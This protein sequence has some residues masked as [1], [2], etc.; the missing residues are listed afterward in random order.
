MLLRL[1]WHA[2]VESSQ[3]QQ[4]QATTIHRLL[5]Y[6]PPGGFTRNASNPIDADA[7]VV[8]ESSMLDITLARELCAALSPKTRLV[9]IGDPDQ[10]PSIGAGNVRFLTS[11][12]SS[13]Y[14]FVKVAGVCAHTP[15]S[16]SARWVFCRSC[17]TRSAQVSWPRESSQPSSG[18]RLRPL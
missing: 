10:L 11:R 6:K 16:L 9:L 4:A 17:L 7:V 5:E 8:D 12:G 14:F 13:V 15:L 2:D 18:K 3:E 1:I